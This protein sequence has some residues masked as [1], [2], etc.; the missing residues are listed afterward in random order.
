M[1]IR[2]AHFAFVYLS[3]YRR[4][5]QPTLHQ[6]TDVCELIAHVIEVEKQWV[7]FAAVD[8]GGPEHTYLGTISL[9]SLDV[10]SRSVRDLALSIT[11][12][13][14]LCVRPLTGQA[15]PLTRLLFQRPKGEMNKRLDLLAHAT[16]A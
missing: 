8:A 14:R 9:S 10:V 2:A 6:L 15:D 12:V 16:D 13:P 5:R 1:T 7:C 4:P 11:P 3:L